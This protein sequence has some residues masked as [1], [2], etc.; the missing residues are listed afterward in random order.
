MKAR[1]G[2]SKVSIFENSLDRSD[3]RRIGNIDGVTGRG[4]TSKGRAS[5]ELGRTGG[6]VRGRTGGKGGKGQLKQWYWEGDLS[7]SA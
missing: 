5:G 2:E 3:T 6:G 4:K 1:L 7:F